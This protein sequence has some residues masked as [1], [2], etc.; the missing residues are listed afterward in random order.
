MTAGSSSF[1]WDYEKELINVYKHGVDFS[2]AA[3][4]FTD[5]KRKVYT[6]LKHSKREQ[7]YFC[8]GKVEDRIIT[9]RFTY[10]GEKVR[11]IG[12]GYWRK[13]GRYYGKEEDRSG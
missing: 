6:D 13:G 8:I 9:V 12:A 5:P 4:V 3:K 11:I 10:R 1:I 7:R 2:T